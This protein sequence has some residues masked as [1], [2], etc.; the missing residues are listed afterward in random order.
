[1]PAP[2]HRRLWRTV[3]AA[4]LAAAPLGALLALSPAAARGRTVSVLYAG[5]LATINDQVLGPAFTRTDGIGYTGQG[6]ATLALA[7][8]ITG[9][10]ITADAFEAVGTGGLAAVGRAIMPWAV[11]V[12]AQPLVVMYN[13][14]SRWAPAFKAIASGRRPLKDL[15]RLLETPG[16]KLGRTDPAT[17]PQGQAFVLMVRL[18]TNLYRL[19]AQTP[20]RVLGALENPAQVFAETALPAELQAGGVDAASGFRPQ[21]IQMHLPYIALPPSL[22]FASAADARTYAQA[23]FV[24]PLT[25][26]KVVGAP[27]AIWAGPLFQAGSH[28]SLGVRWVEFLMSAQ[29]QAD[30]KKNGY[31]PVSLPVYGRRGLLPAALVREMKAAG[32]GR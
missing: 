2:A 22:D 1:M 19:P 6:A 7:R 5:S 11:A 29:G 9:G 28:T 13:P 8:E 17:D 12:A 23:S 3:L 20:R 10:E 26:A 14:R 4:A 15:F 27:L 31:A 21:A 30:L 18:A 32:H 25:H 24:L 16:L